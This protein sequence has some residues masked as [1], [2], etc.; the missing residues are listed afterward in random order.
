MADYDERILLVEVSGFR[1]RRVMQTNHATFQVPYS[2]LARILRLVKLR[3][4]KIVRIQPLTSSLVT[5]TGEMPSREVGE[6]LSTEVGEPTSTE[7]GESTSTEVGEP[8]STEDGESTSTEA[9]ESASSL[10]DKSAVSK[11]SRLSGLVRRLLGKS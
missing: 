6:P 10:T 4:G 7:D 3:G 5:E 8:T 2:S 1:Q 9:G 11:Q